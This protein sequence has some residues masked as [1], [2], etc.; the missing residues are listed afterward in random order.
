MPSIDEIILSDPSVLGGA[1]VFRRTRVPVSIVFENLAA[2]LSLDE[3]LQEF[4]TLDRHDVVAVL[5][6]AP[7]RLKAA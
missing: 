7:Q 4:P 1:P 6:Q 2:G 5:R 3:V